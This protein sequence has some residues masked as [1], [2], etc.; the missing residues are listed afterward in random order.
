MARSDDGIAIAQRTLVRLQRVQVRAYDAVHALV[1]AQISAVRGDLANPAAHTA[2]LLS[3]R[4]S[5]VLH[6]RSVVV[7]QIPHSAH[8]A[9]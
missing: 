8:S 3:K 9:T 4:C 2:D 5:V 1:T 7:A 6:N